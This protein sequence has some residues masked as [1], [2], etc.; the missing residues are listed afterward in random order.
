VSW[1]TPDVVQSISSY[2]NEHQSDSV[3][4]IV[5]RNGA[6]DATEATL[7]D[8]TIEDA[9][10]STPSGLLHVPWSAPLMS[11]SQIR[12]ELVNLALF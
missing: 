12:E 7:T 2:M 6:P 10:F 4:E 9:V 8:L 3:L 11:R 5:H 1:L